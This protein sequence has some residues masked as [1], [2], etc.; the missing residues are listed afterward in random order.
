M[1]EETENQ[2]FIPYFIVCGLDLKFG[3]EP[4]ESLSGLDGLEWENENGRDEWI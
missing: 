1:G 2:K 4:D 3:L